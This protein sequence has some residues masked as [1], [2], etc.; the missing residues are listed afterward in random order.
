MALLVFAGFASSTVQA[1]SR[2]LLFDILRNGKPIGEHELMIERMGS[3]THVVARSAIDVTLLGFP[4][5]RMRYEARERW[6]EQGIR[7]LTVEVDDDGRETRIVG[8][9]REDRFFWSDLD[10]REYSVPM[11]VF[12]TNHW[13][14]KVLET[15]RVL[16]T[17]TGQMNRVS[18]ATDDDAIVRKTRS[19]ADT[20]LDVYRYEGDLNLQ[21]WYDTNGLWHGLRFKGR[22]G[23]D[24]EY[25]CRNCAD[26]TIL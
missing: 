26:P 25:V 22:D 9:R 4:L 18:I 10:G 15:D 19:N 23:S 13:N 8:Q 11:P 7:D 3:E 6:D 2:H 12:P 21:S 24:I 1:E 20:E 16:N 5:Y 14:P 17:L